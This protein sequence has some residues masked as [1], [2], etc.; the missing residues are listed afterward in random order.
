VGCL[1]FR[2]SLTRA[3][4]WW[5]HLPFVERFLPEPDQVLLGALAALDEAQDARRALERRGVIG[6]ELR[7]AE[8]READ[9]RALVRHLRR[10]RIRAGDWKRGQGLES[11]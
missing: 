2:G 4:S 6:A 10:E 8:E 9:A 3:L 5:R 11:A 1:V 7:A